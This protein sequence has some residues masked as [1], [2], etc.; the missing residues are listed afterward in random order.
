MPRCVAACVPGRTRAVLA[1]CGGTIDRALT[2]VVAPK[3][4]GE[5]SCARRQD[6]QLVV[7]S[8]GH[9]QARR[10]V[11]RRGAMEQG[12]H[13]T[14]PSRCAPP[15]QAAPARS[16]ERAAGPQQRHGGERWLTGSD[17]G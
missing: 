14:V 5:A 7:A 3:C 16:G 6:R 10:P 2:C 12:A 13:V 11:C 8:E 17:Y 9:E 1:A 4:T 15:V